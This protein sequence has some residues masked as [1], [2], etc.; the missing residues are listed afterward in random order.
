[1]PLGAT[2]LDEN[3]KEQP[4]VMGS[5]G[6]GPARIAAAAIEQRADERG[7]VWPASIAPWAVHLVSLAKAGEPEREAADGIYE[8]LRAAGVETL[9]DDRDAGPGE[10]LTDAELL[11]CPL[12]LTAGK[13]SLASGE[14]EAQVRRGQE[15]RT[16]PLEGA[17]D[18][19]VELWRT[20]A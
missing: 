18:A 14:L 20:L 5:Y 7:I 8:G 10:K 19:A 15:S 1:V 16:L 4:I 9:Y 12:R 2:F 6:I 3:G 17:A 11:G 13:R